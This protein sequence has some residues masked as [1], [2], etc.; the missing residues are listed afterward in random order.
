LWRELHLDRFWAVRL[1]PKPQEKD[2]VIRLLQV[3]ASYRLIA[4]GQRWRLHRSGLARAPWPI[5]W[6][7]ISGWRRPIRLY[8]MST[9]C[10]WR[11]K[12]ALFS[13]S[14]GAVGRD[15]FNADFDVLL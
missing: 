2:A 6:G 13:Q 3:L 10:C 1:A 9:T 7:P 8:A 4:P 12:E 14:G 11:H 15:L 5:C